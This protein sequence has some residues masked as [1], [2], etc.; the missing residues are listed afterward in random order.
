MA[1]NESDLPTEILGEHLM[2]LQ[3]AEPCVVGLECLK[4]GSSQNA[5]VYSKTARFWGLHLF[6]LNHDRR[7]F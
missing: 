5:T 4:L 6:F 1:V 2:G 3:V 7:F